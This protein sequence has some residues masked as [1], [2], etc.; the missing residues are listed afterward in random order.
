MGVGGPEAV[1]GVGAVPEQAV[2]LATDAFQPI[3]VRGLLAAR[4]LTFN[5]IVLA[6]G[7]AF[8]VWQLAILNARPV[9]FIALDA[10]E[11]RV[12]LA[13][14]A[15]VVIYLLGVVVFLF[16]FRRAYRNLRPLR[17]Q[18]SWAPGW[19]I[20]AWFVPLVNLYLP[21][22]ITM[23]IW[24]G[25]DPELQDLEARGK[26]I[27]IPI[28]LHLWWLSWVGGNIGDRVYSTMSVSTVAAERS[29]T[30]V[31]VVSLVIQLVCGL[32][33]V[34]LVRRLTDRQEQRAA[35]LAARNT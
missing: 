10:S 18:M 30:I 12:A 33:A 32:F 7:L 1:R 11:G 25:T 3:R 8:A 4:W 35:A 22:R 6:V 26:P 5:V 24:E 34:I 29:A 16:W 17:G 21:W 23:E 27:R 15:G 2:P 13:L 19:A 28:W 9:D 20:G 14:V 31:L